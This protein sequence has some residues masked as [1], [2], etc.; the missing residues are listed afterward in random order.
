MKT[1]LKTCFALLLFGMLFCTGVRAQDSLISL[2][3]DNVTLEEAIGEIEKQSE[4]SF[5]YSKSLVDMTQRV[6]L[7]V[8]DQPL[9]T[10]LDR[11]FSGTRISWTARDRQII[12]SRRTDEPQPSSE[13]PVEKN[14]ITGKVLD[15]S[16]EPVIGAGI[17]IEGTMT[18]TT[19]DLNGAFN[20]EVEAG[21]VLTVTSLG[22]ETTKVAVTAGRSSYTITLQES[23][24]MLDD[25]VSP[26]VISTSGMATTVSSTCILAKMALLSAAEAA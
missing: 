24:E 5:L 14:V 10:V 7:K 26:T 6:T 4:Y 15:G 23:S 8:T 11:L 17:I 9:R 3:A 25:V 16:G 20:L 22:Y 13:V 18:G 1:Y 19:T 12:L 2:D 21:S